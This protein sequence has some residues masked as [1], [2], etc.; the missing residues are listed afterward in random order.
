MRC[1][2]DTQPLQPIDV[3]IHCG[4]ITGDS[5]LAEYQAALDLLRA[6]DAPLKLLIPGNHDFTLDTPTFQQ[7]CHKAKRRGRGMSNSTLQQYYGAPGEAKQLLKEA[8]KDGI[9][10]LEEGTHR[11][12]L[13]NGALLTVF[14]SP[15]TPAYGSPGFQYTT[16]QGH[17]FAIQEDVDVVVTHGPPRGVLDRSWM[18][19]QHAGSAVLYAAV[20]RARPRL[21]CFG[22]IHEGWGAELVT[23]REERDKKNRS[24]VLANLGSI[25]PLKGD[26]VDMV[27]EKERRLGEYARGKCVKTSHCAGD[28]LPVV[29]G[30][31]TLFVNAA[32]LGAPMRPPWVVD[33]ELPA[34]ETRDGSSWYGGGYTVAAETS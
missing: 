13:P 26:A 12:R 24:T 1:L 9:L 19:G 7:M 29:P 8:A 30:E 6:I 18:T 34:V 33:I 23:W 20:A 22:H 16:K 4:D 32:V 10:Y 5:R 3:V 14:A 27:E 31:N 28:V 21:H 25:L 11:L 15:Y 2:P 17:D